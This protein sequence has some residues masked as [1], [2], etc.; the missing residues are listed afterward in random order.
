[1]SAIGLPEFKAYLAARS[2]PKTVSTQTDCVG[3]YLRWLALQPGPPPVS[4]GS[5]QAY[6]D[7]K[8]NV[9]P[10]TKTTEA[11][12]I[13]RYLKFL[14]LPHE[15]DAP[16]VRPG[17]PVYLEERD[18]RK[19]IKAAPTLL[20]RTLLIVL[21]DTGARISEVLSLLVADLDLKN[22]FAALREGKGGA[23]R[24]LIL[25][26]QGVDAIKAWLA[27]RLDEDPLLF[28]GVDYHEARLRLR[29][30]AERAGVKDFKIHRIRH[31]RAVYDRLHGASLEDV[32]N[33]LGHRNISTTAAFYSG[34][35]P[36]DLRRKIPSWRTSSTFQVAPN[37]E[38]EQ[39]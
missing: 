34:L 14:G 9:T 7:S 20:E 6:L 12:A 25:T 3:R 23:P 2:R 28:L 30:V 29:A 36:T 5:A 27:A 32:S 24:D 39:D 11:I 10:A 18:I 17:R 21:F 13:R 31:S 19:L 33:H 22:G 8:V 35:R 1:M 26:K 16:R 38:A 37:P 15:L 4:Q